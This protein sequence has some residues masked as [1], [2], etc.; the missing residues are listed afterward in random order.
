MDVFCKTLRNVASTFGITLCSKCLSYTKMQNLGY[1]VDDDYIGFTVCR[2]CGQ[3][4][5]WS[6][7]DNVAC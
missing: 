1:T 2:K 3:K 5:W 6:N 7:D 4:D